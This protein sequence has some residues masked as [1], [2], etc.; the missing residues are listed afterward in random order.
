[1]FGPKKL[2]NVEPTPYATRSDFCRIFKKD[3]NR[4]YLLSFLLTGNHSLAEKCFVSGLED[5]AKG[6][7]VFKEWADSWARRAVIQNAI[8]RVRPRAKGG[9]ESGAESDHSAGHAL[10]PPEIAGVLLLPAFERFAFV[11]SV[12]EGYSDQESSLLLG[13]TRAEVAEARSQ[14]LSRIGESEELQR[15]LL[16]IAAGQTPGDERGSAFRSAALSAWASFA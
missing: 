10:Q 7:P 15:K 8:R 16:S 5:S 3:M 4:L 2:A 1:M 14:A 9:S 11:M 6:N 12:L 13:C